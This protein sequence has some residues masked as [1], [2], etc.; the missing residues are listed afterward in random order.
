MGVFPF[1]GSTMKLLA[2]QPTISMTPEHVFRVYVAVPSLISKSKKTQTLSSCQRL[3]TLLIKDNVDFNSFLSLTC[4][5]NSD[6]T[7]LGA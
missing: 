2:C 1:N 3:A 6:K 4:W 5:I 7:D